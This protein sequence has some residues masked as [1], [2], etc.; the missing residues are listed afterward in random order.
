MS[1]PKQPNCN[2]DQIIENEREWR[3]HTLQKIEELDK[4]LDQLNK[5]T[6]TLKAKTI[7]LA[8]LFGGA[9]ALGSDFLANFFKN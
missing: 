8:S 2:I 1:E 7:T 3:R 4:K 9:S 5:D 6:L